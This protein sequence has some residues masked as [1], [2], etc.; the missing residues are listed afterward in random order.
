MI[1]L[2]SFSKQNG[3]KIL[4]IATNFGMIASQRQPEDDE[5]TIDPGM[6]IDWFSQDVGKM[7]G[8]NAVAAAMHG[9]ER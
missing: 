7:S 8:C 2:D 3:H 9:A 4:I 5:V 6:I 1:R